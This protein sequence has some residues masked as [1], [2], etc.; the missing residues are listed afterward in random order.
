MKYKLVSILLLSFFL[1][2]VYGQEIDL[3]KTFTPLVSKGVIPE[4]FRTLS[5][6]KF[7]KDKSELGN[8]DKRQTKKT[9]EAFLLQSNFGIDN[10]LLSGDVIFGDPVTEYINKIADQVLINHKKL[11]SELRFYVLKSTTVNAF[12]TNQGIIFVSLGLVAQVQNEAQLAYILAHEIVHYTEKHV[13]NSYVDASKIAKDKEFQRLKYDDKII[14]LSNYSKEHE[15][16]AD[17]KGLLMFLETNYSVKHAR[18]VFDVLQYSYLPFDEVPIDKSFFETIDYVFP[19]SYVLEELNGIKVDDD[20]DDSKSSHPNIRKRS[21]RFDELI[22]S[23]SKDELRKAFLVSESE[24]NYA[25]S[26]SR[27]EMSR[28]YLIE[29]DYG[30]AIYNSFLLLQTYPDNAYAKSVIG[31]SLYSLAKY[32]KSGRINRVLNNY[33]KIEGS[34][35][36]LFYFLSKL[37]AEELSILAVKYLWDSYQTHGDVETL[38]LFSETA[39]KDLIFDYDLKFNYLLTKTR[40]EVSIEL[41]EKEEGK[42]EDEEK[43]LSKYDK[44]KKKKE[45]D[46]V[47]GSE[48]YSRYAF[49]N[50]INSNSDFASVF[51]SNIEEY[52]KE[53]ELIEINNKLSYKEKLKK[54]K[55][56]ER[57]KK[58]EYKKGKSFG[59]NKI[60][61][62][63]PFYIS[64]DTRKTKKIKH[65]AS[66]EKLIRFNDKLIQNANKVGIENELLSA[67]LLPEDDA[68]FFND[69]SLISDWLSERLD[70]S[71]I[72][73]LNSECERI[74][75]ISEK[76]GTDYFYFT[77]IVNVRERNSE[78]YLKAFAYVVFGY[79]IFPIPLAI[80]EIVKVEYSTSYH[81]LVL[82]FDT[83]EIVLARTISFNNNDSK[84]FLNS[85]IYNMMYQMKQK[86]K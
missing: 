86:S 78:R 65:I 81:N 10:L 71:D 49:V 3:A 41:A 15:F 74:K 73:V 83:G 37:N 16:E 42:T 72:G 31:K 66:E 27:F 57:A 79:L 30:M 14:E 29:R 47:V 13:I 77:G 19:E 1:W 6:D 59:I 62:V 8:Q 40:E 7:Y 34:S 75:K 46:K 45:T 21:K 24:F 53:R 85:Y 4:D 56:A 20:Y 50:L 58:K 25:R 12:S 36:Q 32:K 70:H 82:N 63:N 9:K 38:K 5:K 60:V 69:L 22:S 80:N 68:E 17:E 51:Q 52:E 28:L 67:K 33:K 54:Q 61:I 48:S 76:Y 39:L 43:E 11:R 26:M 23:H 2:P 55:E 35:Q 44:I 84:D 64:A 18:G